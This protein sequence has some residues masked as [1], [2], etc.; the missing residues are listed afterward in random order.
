MICYDVFH[1]NISLF[2]LEV[3]ISFYPSCAFKRS[4]SRSRSWFSLRSSL[5]LV[6]VRYRS[7]LLRSLASL[8]SFI[9]RS[10]VHYAVFFMSVYRLYDATL[11]ALRSMFASYVYKVRSASIA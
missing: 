5:F 1:L 9:L 6:L 4:R 3:P 2:S 7:S 8:K 10:T 11:G